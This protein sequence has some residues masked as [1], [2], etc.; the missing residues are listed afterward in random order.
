[1]DSNGIKIIPKKKIINRTDM[2]SF[3]MMGRENSDDEFSDDD[4][5]LSE[6]S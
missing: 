5:S 2:K 3:A 6:S 1:M 4:L